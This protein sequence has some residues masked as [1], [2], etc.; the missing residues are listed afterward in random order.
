MKNKKGFAEQINEVQ[1]RYIY[2]KYPI[3]YV[4]TPEYIQYLCRKN[5]GCNLSSKQFDDLVSEVMMSDIYQELT[6]DVIEFIG[7]FLKKRSKNNYYSL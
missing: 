5:F 2:E 7:K 4:Y 6:V 1:E 3:C